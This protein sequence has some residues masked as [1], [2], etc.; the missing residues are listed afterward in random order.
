M[1]IQT[2]FTLPAIIIPLVGLV[3]EQSFSNNL[4]AV[5]LPIYVPVFLSTTEV[6]RSTKYGSAVGL[7][8]EA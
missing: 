3:R 5:F 6:V 8:G 7:L 4:T 1:V 2:V